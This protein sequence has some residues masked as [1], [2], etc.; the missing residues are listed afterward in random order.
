MILYTPFSAH[1]KNIILKHLRK[2]ILFQ[3]ENIFEK[4][5]N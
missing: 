2:I 5:I 4:K 3:L 1:K